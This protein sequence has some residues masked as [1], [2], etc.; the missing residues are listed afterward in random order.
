MMFRPRES[1]DL[2]LIRINLVI[3]RN[4]LI[5][6]GC[7]IRSITQSPLSLLRGLGPNSASKAL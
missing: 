2:R 4:P 7:T 3:T 5:C 6:A 1:H